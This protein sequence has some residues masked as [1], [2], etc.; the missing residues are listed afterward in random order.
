MAALVLAVAVA[1]ALAAQ[2]VAGR[3]L[4]ED[5]VT[6]ASGV[7]VR[8]VR[9]SDGRTVT[10]V[11]TSATGEYRA[12]VGVDSVR[13]FALRVGM[14]PVELGALRLRTGERREL[15][16]V[17]AS[18]VFEL[19]AVRSRARDRC[20]PREGPEARLAASAFEQART[21]LE[22]VRAAGGD[23]T[24]RARVRTVRTR[25]S[26][27]E[28]RV[29]EVRR[30]E[31]ETGRLELAFTPADTL[32]DSGFVRQ[33][34][35]GTTTYRAPGLDFFIHP[36]FLEEHCIV[37]VGSPD[38]DATRVGIGYRPSRTRRSVV[39]VEGVLW[40]Q[41]AGA[42]LER[43]EFAYAGLPGLETSV[44]P[45]GWLEFVALASDRWA[46]VRWEI[47]MPRV[48]E[49]LVLSRRRSDD[50]LFREITEVATTAG[51][52]LEI[53]G[54]TG[55]DF[56][57]A[58]IDSVDADGAL[59]LHADHPPPS[60]APC[61]A[62]DGQALLH[63]RVEILRSGD[64]APAD[65]VLSWRRPHD[66]ADRGEVPLAGDGRFRMCGVPT[67]LPIRIAL[68]TGDGGVAVLMVR[69]PRERTVGRLV[70]R[71]SAEE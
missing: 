61:E 45:G 30:R 1:P 63:G 55:L 65:G 31:V 4:R 14:R 42:E 18:E 24:R 9:A 16:G 17:L 62:T 20:G 28:E 3:L 60:A 37:L 32:Y 48:G 11:T 21:A 40:L 23:T 67:G 33:A 27:G 49:A 66:A 69:V 15:A 59:V 35:D 2:E 44:R 57:A 52:V 29:L 36:R 53:T 50:V 22:L 46:L 39:Q 6:P 12:A 5:G 38:G 56:S 70:L 25:W 7:L 51:E 54:A 41:R 34:R 19:P 43:V 8:V 71:F 64:W 26:A 13:L 10:T 58:A 68:R 47:R